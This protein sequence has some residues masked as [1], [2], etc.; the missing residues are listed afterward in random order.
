[1]SLAYKKKKQSF[2]SSVRQRHG[3]KRRLKF[4]ELYKSQKKTLISVREATQQQT[5][6]SKIAEKEK[7]TFSSRSKKTATMVQD[8]FLF[9]S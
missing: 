9:S 3:T 4:L 6:D 8:L 5:R 1:V 7:K 2:I